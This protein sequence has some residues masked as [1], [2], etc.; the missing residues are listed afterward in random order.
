MHVHHFIILLAV[1]VLISIFATFVVTAKAASTRVPGHDKPKYDQDNNG[2]PDAG[3]E[4]NGHYTSLYAYDNNGDW[5][6]DLGDGRVQGTVGSVSDLDQATL[7]KCDYVVN[8]RGGFDNNPFMDNGWIQNLINCKGFDDNG[9]Y[10][11]DIVHKSDP[12]YRGN[13][14]WAVWGD[15][16]YHVLTESKSGNLVRP[17][18][19]IN[20]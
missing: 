10:N 8:Y 7:T 5:Y 15:W 6:W 3:V 12:R 16:E 17:D 9:Q 2:Y 18:K 4:V 1:T 13:P 11:Y 20:N 19:P 14:D